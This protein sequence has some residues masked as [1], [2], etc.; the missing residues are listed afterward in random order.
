MGLDLAEDGVH[1]GAFLA[2]EGELEHSVAGVL[3]DPAA[4]CK[5]IGS[6]CRQGRPVLA[7]EGSSSLTNIVVL[8]LRATG[9]VTT[10]I[11]KRW[12]HTRQ[13]LSG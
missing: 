9:T 8:A 2:G 13:T 11:F 12:Y 5:A 3:A 7:V 4:Y 6:Q 1:P 10:I